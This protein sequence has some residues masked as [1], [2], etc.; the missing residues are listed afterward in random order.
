MNKRFFLIY[1]ILCCAN[2]FAQDLEFLIKNDMEVDRKDNPFSEIV[3][4]KKGN[5]VKTNFPQVGFGIGVVDSNIENIKISGLIYEKNK[6]E[7]RFSVNDLILKN[8]KNIL[9]NQFKTDFWIPK[10]YYDQLTQNNRNELMFQN[11]TFWDKW[12]I[13][14]D[15]IKT[16]RD[17]FSV[18]R[19][20]V[21]DYFI[22]VVIDTVAWESVSFI[23]YLDEMTDKQF[24]YNVRIMSTNYSQYVV[25]GQ[26]SHPEFK[27]L[28]EKEKPFKI[29]FTIDGDYLNM[30]IDRESEKT[31]FKTL[32][33]SSP[34][35]C[36][37]IE[38]WI[39]EKSNDLS[40]VIWPHHADGTS[41]YEDTIRYP[42]PVVIEE[43]EEIK[44][45]EYQE[46]IVEENEEENYV[47]TPEEQYELERQAA[48]DNVDNFDDYMKYTKKYDYEEYKKNLPEYIGYLFLTRVLPIIVILLFILLVIKK[49]KNKQK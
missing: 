33:R 47:P 34:G 15:E 42:D 43:P 49:I 2:L 1:L 46:K 24:V 10:Y 8:N 32:V 48:E 45:V 5:V 36:E 28:F 11:E 44:V 9:P 25:K 37:Q 12:T 30:Y 41:E 4:L 22:H 38:N 16:W 39:A 20:L 23:G 14:A 3:S 7:Y 29:I 17:D 40:E 26:S 6:E 27:F 21:G 13:N 35:A 19:F 18:Q 31:L